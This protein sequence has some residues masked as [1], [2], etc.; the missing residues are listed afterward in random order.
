M[1]FFD[2]NQYFWA[3]ARV[4][5]RS[6]SEHLLQMDILPPMN[7]SQAAVKMLGWCNARDE[8]EIPKFDIILSLKELLK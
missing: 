5:A 8:P 3:V 2:I 1:F 6:V 4:Y 7:G